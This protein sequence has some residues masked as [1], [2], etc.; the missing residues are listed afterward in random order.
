MDDYDVID[1]R[2][3]EEEDYLSQDNEDFGFSVDIDDVFDD[4]DAVVAEDDFDIDEAVERLYN[5]IYG[6]G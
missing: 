6:A 3:F 5:L 4:V 2:G 1:V